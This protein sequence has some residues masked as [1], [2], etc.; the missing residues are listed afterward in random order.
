MAVKKV[1]IA[2]RDDNHN[3]YDADGN[4]YRT[5]GDFAPSKGQWVWVNGKYI[6]GH[7][8]GGTAPVIDIE[9]SIIPISC[10]LYDADGMYKGYGYIDSNGTIHRMTDKEFARSMVNDKHYVFGRIGSDHDNLADDSCIDDDGNLWSG[11]VVEESESMTDVYQSIPLWWRDN[12]EGTTENYN[13][14]K[15]TYT[16]DVTTSASVDVYKNSIKQGSYNIYECVNDAISQITY[17]LNSYHNSSKADGDI[18]PSNGDRPRP[19]IQIS[20]LLTIQ[21]SDFYMKNDGDFSITIMVGVTGRCYPYI[22]HDFTLANLSDL[23]YTD[24]SIKEWIALECGMNIYYHVSMSGYEQYAVY[25]LVSMPYPIQMEGKLLSKNKE[26]VAVDGIG[27]AKY[28]YHTQFYGNDFKGDKKYRERLVFYAPS[29]SDILPTRSYTWTDESRVIHTVDIESDTTRT[30]ENKE[31]E[32]LKLGDDIER[33]DSR[34]SSITFQLSDSLKCIKK[35]VLS[36]M[37]YEFYDGNA[38]IYTGNTK[39]L[40]YGYPIM[41]KI[42]NAYVCGLKDAGLAY[43]NS[44]GEATIL[45]NHEYSSYTYN[46]RL[47]PMQLTRFRMF[48]N[49]I[50]S[51]LGG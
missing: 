43:I 34:P 29:K 30:A 50:E 16:R 7:T 31:L 22:S 11:K 49:N 40:G 6:Y 37:Y 25:D 44:D 28:A 47:S 9:P 46:H 42:R 41:A 27:E 10:L 32:N 5:M 14:L 48:V 19:S 35:D 3:Y 2:S 26:A 20:K 18:Y 36:M 15:K 17:K 23:T 33:E 45:I 12:F 24:K 39:E 13:T 4:A 51:K 21:I 8:T 1:Q 38:L